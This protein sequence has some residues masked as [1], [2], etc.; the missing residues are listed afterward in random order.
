MLNVYISGLTDLDANGSYAQIGTHDGYPYYENVNGYLL[1]Y[2]LQN[3][4][5]TLSAGYFI[6]KKSTI[7]N[8]IPNFIPKYVNFSTDITTG[9]WNSLMYQSS[10]ETSVGNFQLEY[11]SSSSSSTSSSSSIIFSRSS[12]SSLSSLST[13]SSSTSSTSSIIFSRSS[14]SSSSSSS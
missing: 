10:G 6:V 8:S 13:N 7:N 2:N 12:M 3:M 5:Y 4:P 1:I 14:N 11:L 9:T